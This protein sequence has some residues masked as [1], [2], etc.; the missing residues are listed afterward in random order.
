[1]TP[2]L[3]IA[4]RRSE[5]GLAA[6]LVAG[7]LAGCGT[8]ASDAAE[9]VFAQPVA[10]VTAAEL[11]IETPATAVRIASDPIT[12]LYQVTIAHGD[13]VSPDVRLDPATRIAT[14]TTTSSG[15]A[16]SSDVATV[17]VLLNEQVPW[18]VRINGHTHTLDLELERIH[19]VSLDVLADGDS[20]GARLP[21]PDATLPVSVAG[22][23]S[24]VD[25][26]VQYAAVRLRLDGGAGDLDFLR[27]EL[28]SV[29]AGDT[30]S[31]EGDFSTAL[32]R[33]DLHVDR[34]VARVTVHHD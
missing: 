19:L 26:N 21:V 17:D 13:A 16:G 22:S 10:G 8:P 7:G 24:T 33:Y 12:D 9:Q 27:T 28:R 23:M 6:A 29:G 2:L 15:S 4:L 3:R 32:T 25:V 1:M 31:G 18:R 30:R 11:D 20:L 5:V 34:T 14:V